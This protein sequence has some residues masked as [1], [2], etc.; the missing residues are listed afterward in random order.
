MKK[1]IRRTVFQSGLVAASSLI[2][3]LVACSAAVAETADPFSTRDLAASSQ[4]GSL[5]QPVLAFPC[6][7]EPAG[8]AASL[9][10]P[11]IVE[12][13]L[14]N[15]PQ[16]REA[17][18]NA[19]YQA[20][21][22]GISRSAFLPS[23]SIS[24]AASKNR[25]DGSSTSTQQS[26]MASLSYLLYDFGARDAALEN[27]RQ[28]LA[29]ANAT[30]DATIQSVFL[31][32]VQAYY[33]LFAAQAAVESAKEAEKSALESLNSASARYNVGAGTPADK[34]Q[35]QTAYSQAVLN[36]IQ[37]EGNRQNAQGILANSM[38]MDANQR[39][40]AAPPLVQVPDTHFERDIGK[41]IEEARRQRPDLAAA[42]S[43][44]N[45]AKSSADAARASGMPTVS[46]STSVNRTHSS[47]ADAANSSALG[48]SVSF[49]LFTGYN[50][51]YR[52]RAAEEQVETRLAQ[53]DRLSQQVA[54]DVWKAYQG[55]VTGTQAVRS[56]ADL[57]ASATQSERVALGRYKAG[58]GNIL[59]VLTAQAALGSARLQNIQATYDWYLAKAS[60]AQSMGKLDFAAIE[61]SSPG[62]T[63]P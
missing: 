8:Q 22:A 18:A 58:V 49:P 19:R 54:L 39:F 61:T 45:A 57:V 20:A 62:Q 13:A 24:G 55:V 5:R 30:Q 12:R 9:S 28:I 48:V 43:Q 7:L 38:G 17:W 3:L 2:G 29:A 50:T 59:E 27:A 6:T 16:T 33:Q 10:L 51:T 4:A 35:A 34:L 25:S 23:I 31:S 40:G 46:L 15:N 44:V 36:R 26:V 14:C 21:Q 56:S 41:L 47:I 53:R 11:D 42:E 32:A 52:I 37:A 1:M 60:L 63:I